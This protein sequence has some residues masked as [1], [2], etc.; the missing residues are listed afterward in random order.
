[1]Y[2]SPH[3]D[4][5]NY[6]HNRTNASPPVLV[7]ARGLNLS[8]VVAGG[9]IAIEFDNNDRNVQASGLSYRRSDLHCFFLQL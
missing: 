1:M 8:R 4:D 6:A 2:R 9:G 7:Q 3:F 5:Y